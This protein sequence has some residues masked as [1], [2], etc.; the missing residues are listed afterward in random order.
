M[1]FRIGGDR[2]LE[3]V[4]LLQPFHERGGTRIAFG[5]RNEVPAV[6]RRRITAQGDDVTHARFPVLVRDLAD[7]VLACSNARQ[8]RRR[9]KR[10]F[11]RDA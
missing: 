3:V 8:V 6:G 10:G 1:D 7:L 5:M 11:A 9:D 4:T 2:D